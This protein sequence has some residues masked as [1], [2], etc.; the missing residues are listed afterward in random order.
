[1]QGSLKI[2]RLLKFFIIDL[3][4][5]CVCVCVCVCVLHMRVSIYSRTC[6]RSIRIMNLLYSFDIVTITPIMGYKIL[7]GTLSPKKQSVQFCRSRAI[8]ATL[9]TWKDKS[10]E[11]IGIL[12]TL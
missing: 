7:P 3:R 9:A 2:S 4:D 12:I 10:D 8:F 5:V 6:T 11:N 1:L